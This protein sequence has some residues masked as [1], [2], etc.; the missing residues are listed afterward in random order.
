MPGG[1][2]EQG[3]TPE[4]A[5]IREIKEETGVAGNVKTKIANSEEYRGNLHQFSSCYLVEYTGRVG[6]PT[7]TEDEER[8]GITNFWIPLSEAR[9]L[10][11]DTSPNTVVG[12]YIKLRDLFF[13]DKWMEL[14][15]DGSAS[16]RGAR[17]LA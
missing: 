9:S 4:Q 7:L 8:D 3:E 13:L 6:D 16:G 5:L 1:G 10:I 2:V 11:I 12:Q 17:Y 14:S 15:V